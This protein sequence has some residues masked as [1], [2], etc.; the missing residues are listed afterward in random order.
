[1]FERLGPNKAR[2]TATAILALF[3]TKKKQAAE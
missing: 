2:D 1:M 3:K